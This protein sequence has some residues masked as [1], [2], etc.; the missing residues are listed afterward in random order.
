MNGNQQNMC[1]NEGTKTKKKKQHSV[2][3][4]AVV[5]EKNTSFKI[6]FGSKPENL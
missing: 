1:N 4:F 5:S 6:K 3:R 2:K